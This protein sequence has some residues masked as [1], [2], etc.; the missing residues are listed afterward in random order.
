MKHNYVAISFN[1]AIFND[2]KQYLKSD[3]IE[4]KIIDP[5]EFL[6]TTQISSDDRF[7]NLVTKDFSLREEISE[8]M[9]RLKCER[10][11]FVHKTACVDGA[12]ISDGCFVYPNVTIYPNATVQQDVIIQANSRISH[13]V[14]I[15][16]GTF[17]GGLVN[18]SGSSNIGKFA[19]LYPSCNIID[20]VSVAD[21]VTIGT[22]TTLRKNIIE[23]GIYSRFSDK[24]KKIN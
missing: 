24:I 7:I 8:H 9:L 4:L 22:G 15:Q 2:L 10:F 5:L 11:T 6:N 18:I 19:K 13:N 3:D 20:K 23:S 1:T 14:K 17:I 12:K 21:Y 16:S